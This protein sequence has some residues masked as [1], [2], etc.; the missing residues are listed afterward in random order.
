MNETT[1]LNT[2]RM[3]YHR[4]K[5]RKGNLE[6]HLR[7]SVSLRRLQLWGSFGNR[8]EF[9]KINAQLLFVSRVRVKSGSRQVTCAT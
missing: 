9:S 4:K 5:E 6:C 8:P 7:I 3:M 2:P 1:P